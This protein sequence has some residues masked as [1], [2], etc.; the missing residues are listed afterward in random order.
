MASCAR[1]S[2]VEIRS[3]FP[4]LENGELERPDDFSISLTVAQRPPDFSDVTLTKWTGCWDGQD[5][6]VK[7]EQIVIRS[8]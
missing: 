3:E 7:M 1:E 2:R 6:P 8:Y 5:Q 4:L